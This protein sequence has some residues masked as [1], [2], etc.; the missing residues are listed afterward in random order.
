M[1]VD[2]LSDLN[3]NNALR[4]LDLL[5]GAVR[6]DLGRVTKELTSNVK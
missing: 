6:L 3:L 1:I 2:N 5:G 4:T